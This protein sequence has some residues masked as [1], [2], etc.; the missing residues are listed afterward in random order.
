MS[1]EVLDQVYKLYATPHLDYGNIIYHK[2][3][4]G[5][6]LEQ[7]HKAALAASGAWKGTNKL[8]LLEE[9]GWETLYSRRRYLFFASPKLHFIFTRKF[10]NIELLSVIL[11]TPANMNLT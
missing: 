2:Y 10:L 9:L 7:T 5:K 6:Q 4:P 3:D 8:R 1:R 11:E